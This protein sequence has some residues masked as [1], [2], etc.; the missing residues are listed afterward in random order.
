[1]EHGAIN[2][3]FSEPD[4][5]IPIADFADEQ[6]STA[7]AIRKLIV[8][9]VLSDKSTKKIRGRWFIHKKLADQELAEK[10]D[11][12]QSNQNG[13]S[14]KLVDARIEKEQWAA[15]LKQIEYENKIGKLVDVDVVQR[16]AFELAR[17]TRDAVLNVADRVGPVLASVTDHRRITQVLKSELKKAMAQLG[18]RL[19]NG[20]G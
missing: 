14:P 9:G 8:A 11:H 18:E 16:E 7:S 2:F 12:L 10:K 5:W 20:N 6:R 3:D 17:E 19:S 13:G 1:M 15:K 4:P